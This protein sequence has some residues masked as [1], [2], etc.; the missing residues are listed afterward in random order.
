MGLRE[1]RIRH[2]L[3][4]PPGARVLRLAPLFFPDEIT[5]TLIGGHGGQ[6]V[7]GLFPAQRRGERQPSSR[8]LN[9]RP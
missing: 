8:R 9:F 3:G 4:F 7:E 1:Y 6:V 5:F 2:P